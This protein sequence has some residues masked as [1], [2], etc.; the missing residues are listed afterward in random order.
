MPTER[1]RWSRWGRSSYERDEDLAAEAAAMAPFVETLPPGVDAEVLSVTSKTKVDAA[2]LD[3]TPSAR[4]VVTTTSGYDH[5]DLV[6]LRARGIAAA[7]CPLVRRDAVVDSALG[8]ML[9]GLRVLGPLAAAAREGRWMRGELPALKPRTLA[10]AR[11]GVV[12]LGVIGQKM[13]AVLGVLGAEVLGV[14]PAGVPEGVRAAELDE[15]LQTCD[16]VTLHCALTPETRGCVSRVRLERARPGLVLV[17]TARGRLVD[18]D[19]ALDAVDAGRLAALG[20][21]V[22]PEEPWARLAEAAQR[23]QVW[24]TPHAAGWHDRLPEQLRAEL[25]A[26]VAGWVR[27]EGLRFGV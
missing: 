9:A 26:T 11:V 24:V 15:V 1:I 10:G 17:N 16:A 6:E 21:D 27:G 18:L 7:R 13:A 25:A 2:F 19:A 3:H 4:L 14:D 8:L 20:V 23:P 5:L 22:F 12:G